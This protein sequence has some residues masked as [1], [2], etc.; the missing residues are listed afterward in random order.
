MYLH[1]YLLLFLFSFCHSSLN[2]RNTRGCQI[3]T[4]I[5]NMMTKCKPTDAA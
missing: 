5:F 2:L 3:E 1:L 4:I